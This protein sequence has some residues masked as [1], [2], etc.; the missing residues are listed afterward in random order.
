MWWNDNKVPLLKFQI[1]RLCR[2]FGTDR[3]IYMYFFDDR[4]D[5]LDAIRRHV[6]TPGLPNNIKLTLTSLD[7]NR[8]VID[9]G[10]AFR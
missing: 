5:I 10:E 7:W 8:K 2:D 6:I 1:N 3:P 9:K 4:L